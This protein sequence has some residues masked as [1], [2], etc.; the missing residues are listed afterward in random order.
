MNKSTV[1]IIVCVI[2]CALFVFGSVS[3]VANVVQNGGVSTIFVISNN[4]D[5]GVELSCNDPYHNVNPAD[6]NRTTFIV[7]IKNTGTHDDTYNVTAGSIEDII[8]T[9]NYIN[10]DQFNPYPISLQAGKSTDFYVT[11][12]V[13]DSVP[14]GEWSVIVEARSQNDTNVYDSLELTVNVKLEK[15]CG[16]VYALD[17]VTPLEN[18]SV[19]Y[20]YVDC[21]WFT[22]ENGYYEIGS[23]YLWR[24]KDVYV[25]DMY[26]YPPSDQIYRYLPLLKIVYLHPEGINWVN[27]T[28]DEY[29]PNIPPEIFQIDGPVLCKVGKEYEYTFSADDPEDDQIYFTINWGDGAHMWYIADSE[30]KITVSKIWHNISNYTICGRPVDEYVDYGE[31]GTLKV[32]VTK[33]KQSTYSLFNLFLER[34]ATLARLLQ[35]QPLA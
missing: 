23:C 8:C 34:F 11:A 14:D 12:E 25:L 10:A 28:L 17:G 20:D 33:N 30:G 31:S 2:M 26:A 18:A 7:K 35:F 13:W 15:L 19:T 6:D 3:S 21:V 9:V 27:F 32:T 5:Y 24:Q 16:Y 1:K 29:R 4:D 22:D